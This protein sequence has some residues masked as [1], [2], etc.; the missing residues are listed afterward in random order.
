MTAEDEG[1]DLLDRVR[2][3]RGY[4]LPLHSVLAEQDP[5]VLAAYEGMMQALY[6]AERRLDAKTKELVYVTV[7]VALGAAE[8]HV[9]AH[10]Q[11]A[12]RE[13]ASAEEVLEALEL[14]IPAAGVA[15]ASAGFALWRRTFPSPDASA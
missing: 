11:R 6:H 13:G 2:G 1:R 5:S 12:H 15:R 7:L 4:V 3:A 8:E 10:M 9:K 14:L